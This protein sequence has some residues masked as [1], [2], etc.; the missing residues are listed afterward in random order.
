VSRTRCSA[1]RCTADA[2]PS[3]AWSLRRSRV[4]AAALR[5]AVAPGTP[6]SLAATRSRILNSARLTSTIDVGPVPVSALVG[7]S[8]H[9]PK[10]RDVQADCRRPPAVASSARGRAPPS[11][12][13]HLA[14]AVPQHLAS[15]DYRLDAATTVAENTSMFL[16]KA[17][18]G[19]SRL[20]WRAR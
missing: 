8:R 20:L 12:P 18:Q 4:C 5:A 9:H 3:E 15:A 19:S 14:A 6:E 17:G 2:G 16:H 10:S 11:N 1:Q 7:R 13:N